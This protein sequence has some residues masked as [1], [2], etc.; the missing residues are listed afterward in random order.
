[1]R[2]AL[3]VTVARMSVRR[4]VDDGCDGGFSPSSLDAA[5]GALADRLP[6]ATRLNHVLTI[7][8]RFKLEQQGK[9]Q[10]RKLVN[11]DGYLRSR[12]GGFFVRDREYGGP[13]TAQ[14]LLVYGNAVAM[15][16]N[17]P[18]DPN[19]IQTVIREVQLLAGVATGVADL[20]H[21]REKDAYVCLLYIFN[22]TTTNPKK[23]DQA[24]FLLQE[25]LHHD[26]NPPP[27]NTQT[28]ALA[29][30]EC[31]LANDY[32]LPTDP[33]FAYDPNTLGA[34]QG[35]VASK[36]REIDQEVVGWA[37]IN[38]RDRASRRQMENEQEE[39]REQRRKQTRNIPRFLNTPVGPQ[40]KYDMG[41]NPVDRS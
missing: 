16:K 40:D 10:Q 31:Q 35:N 12:R 4:V 39:A 18:T 1:L 38:A 29:S 5:I 13:V 14:H 24:K 7:G 17:N 11:T 33:N 34:Y 2:G 9:Q 32:L 26:K 3:V 27:Y 6:V 20:D 36:Q 37:S 23:K 15:W 19:Q 41:G 25:S 22:A 30:L 21:L 8:A 28:A